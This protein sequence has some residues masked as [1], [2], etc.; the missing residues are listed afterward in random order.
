MRNTRDEQ[1]KKSDAF[2]MKCV[3][4]GVVVLAILLWVK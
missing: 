1:Q 4:V 3:I 2:W